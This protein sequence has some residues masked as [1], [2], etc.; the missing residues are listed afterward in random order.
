MQNRIHHSRPHSS[1][2]A[3]SDA[4]FKMRPSRRGFR[5]RV[6]FGSRRRRRLT[7]RRQ[8]WPRPKA[9]GRPCTGPTSGSF[10]LAAVCSLLPGRTLHL[11]SQIRETRPS[12]PEGCCCLEWT[13]S[14]AG[15]H[16]VWGTR[17]RTP[18][19]WCQRVLPNQNQ[20]PLSANGKR[21]SERHDKVTEQEEKSS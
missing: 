14:D 3:P 16:G 7:F 18:W 15:D 11:C 17:E 8:R 5:G 21:S 6:C 2:T 4:P 20:G 10:A 9:L 12:P 1:R 13:D 19:S